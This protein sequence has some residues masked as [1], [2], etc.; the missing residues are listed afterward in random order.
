MTQ[1]RELS[2][3]LSDQIAAGEVI[4]RPSSVIKELVE[5]AIDAKATEIDITFSEGGLKQIVVSDNGLG[6]AADDLSL[7]FKRHATSKITTTDDLFNILTLGFR[8]EALSSIAAVSKVE[9]VTNTGETKGIKAKVQ[10]GMIKS[11]EPAAAKRGTQVIVSDLFFNTPARLKYL[12]SQK[13]EIAKMIDVVNQLALS[14]PDLSFRLFNGSKRL[15]Q[16]TGDGDLKKNIANIYGRQISQKM[17]PFSSENMD[18]EISGYLSLPEM[19]RSNR[20]YI[21]I[22]LNGRFI[23]NYQL[24]RSIIS[25]YGSKLMVGRF[26]VVVLNIKMDANLVDVNVHPTKQEVRLSKE[27]Q[28]K[29]LIEQTFKQ[30]LAKNNLVQD[31]LDN[32]VQPA[33]YQPT[34]QQ[35]DLTLSKSKP[36]QFNYPNGQKYYQIEEDI[37]SFEINQSDKIKLSPTWNENVKAQVQTRPFEE[38]NQQL[39]EV[40]KPKTSSFPDLYFVGQVQL[41]YLIA[42]SD[43]GMYL[44]DQH[45]AQ[46]RL[47]Y[48]KYRETIAEV[49]ND[50][51]TFL[52][53][54]TIE[55]SNS[56]Y[57]KI[58]NYLEELQTLG[59]ELR[60]FGGNTFIINSHP[61]WM[62]ENQESL[63]QEMVDAIQ[64]N[65]K[66]TLKQ[67]REKTA[68]MMSCKNAIKANHYIKPSEAQSLLDQLSQ[69][70]NPYNCPH[71]RPVL[72][73]FSQTD[74]EKMFRRIQQSHQRDDGEIGE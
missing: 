4:E 59:I 53:P 47:N 1:I 72:I 20:N 38:E 51:Q 28:L 37:Q 71:G 39:E 31:G 21:S 50:Q 60:P 42:Q 11:Q 30:T 44:V 40:Q 22:L 74:I 45:A 8:G 68:I 64:D 27:A 62:V 2:Q 58:Q 35:T 43:D 70:K 46:E 17:I 23:K 69:A 33:K 49:S 19:T 48:E 29:E 15:S 18:F 6:I 36:R 3:R 57:L 13:T 52:T 10:E 9:I 56:D 24:S 73:H 25:G 55:L 26:P 63:I 34:Y 16:T 14:Y 12:K 61:T 65:P 54:M 32:L 66:L 5:N 7:A 41:T 67:F